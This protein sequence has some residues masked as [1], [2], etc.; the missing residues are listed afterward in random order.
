MGA[1]WEKRPC[2]MD[3]NPSAWW[4]RTLQP[5]ALSPG[6]AVVLPALQWWEG[7]GTCQ[8]PWGGLGAWGLGWGVVLFCS[9]EMCPMYA[10]LQ[11]GLDGGIVFLSGQREACQMRVRL[12]TLFKKS[13]QMSALEY[14]G[15]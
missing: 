13:I 14:T 2:S 12:I 9:L 15:N 3:T 7:A 8:S 1:H 4:D 11:L 5:P 6:T 10:P